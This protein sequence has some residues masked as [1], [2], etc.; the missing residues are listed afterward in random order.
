MADLAVNSVRCDV[1]MWMMEQDDADDD[2]V[3]DDELGDA[4]G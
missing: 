2:E 1:A 4:S 3:D